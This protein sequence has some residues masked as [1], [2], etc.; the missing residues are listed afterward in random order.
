MADEQTEQK[1]EGLTEEKTAKKSTAGSSGKLVWVIAAAIAVVSA[2][3]G[4][5]ISV[6][7]ADTSLNLFRPSDSPPTPASEPALLIENPTGSE[8]TWYHR[9]DPV[10]ANLDEPGAL[11]YIRLVVYLEMDGAASQEQA[12]QLIESRRPT[13]TNWLQLYLASRSL[14]EVKGERYLRIMQMQMLEGFN[15]I[16]F[17]NSRSL[18]KGVLFA[19]LNIQ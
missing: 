18:I 19:E 13:L 15:Q 1:T 2:G 11:R 5:G 7:S 10:V 8:A 14:E 17:P 4:Y 12:Q 6:L 16:L 9:L 3:G